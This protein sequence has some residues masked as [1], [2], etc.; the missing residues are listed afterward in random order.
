MYRSYVFLIKTAGANVIQSNPQMS[1]TNAIISQVTST[2]IS[3]NPQQ[4]HVPHMRGINFIS[5][6]KFSM[7]PAHFHL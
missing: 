5:F 7:Q 6:M 3:S 4:Q 1:S 2:P